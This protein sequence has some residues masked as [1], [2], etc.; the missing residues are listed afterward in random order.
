MISLIKLTENDKR[1]II[2]L[3][4]LVILLFVISG[5]LGLLVRKIMHRQANKMEDLIFDVV[6]TGVIRDTRKL[7][8]YGFKKNHRQLFKES[9][10]PMIIMAAGCLGLLLYCIINQNFKVDIFDMNKTG[11]GTLFF[12]FDWDHTP[13]TDFFGIKIICNWPPVISSPHWSWD[14]WGSYIFFACMLVGGIWFLVN[15]QA[16]IARTYRLLEKSKTVFNKSL[17]KINPETIE[18]TPIKPE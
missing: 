13:T 10:I 14:A 12:H 11:I 7:R 6:D 5:Y 1:L 3:L 2:V 15:V 16:Y 4:L 17:D 8:I 9:W 18:R